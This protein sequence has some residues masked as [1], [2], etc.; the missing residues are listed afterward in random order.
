M[1]LRLEHCE[2]AHGSLFQPEYFTYIQTPPDASPS[3]DI[4]Q[5]PV[6]FVGHTHV[7]VTLWRPRET[8]NQTTYNFDSEADLGLAN[9][10]LVNVGS[11]GQPRDEDPRAAFALYDSETQRLSI[12]RVD[13]DIQEEARLSSSAGLRACWRSACSWAFDSRATGLAV[14]RGTASSSYFERR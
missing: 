5:R 2:V 14:P 11:V 9:R 13:Y 3:L 10:S 8:P 12:R 4:L 6:C 1:T 7:P